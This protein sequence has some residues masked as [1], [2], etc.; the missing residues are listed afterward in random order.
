MARSQK[1]EWR[2]MDKQTLAS[3]IRYHKSGLDQYRYTMSQSALYLEKQTVIA[4]EELRARVI[5][6][7]SSSVPEP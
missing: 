7:K 5:M 2:T 3:L 4:L 1:G 6:E